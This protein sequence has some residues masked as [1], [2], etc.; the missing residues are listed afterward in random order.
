MSVSSGKNARILVDSGADEHVCPTSHQLL[1]LDQP[2]VA[3]FTMRR[4]T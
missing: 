1:L 4:G 3:H 2:R